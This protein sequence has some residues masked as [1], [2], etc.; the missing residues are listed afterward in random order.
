MTLSLGMEADYASLI[1][2]QQLDSLKMIGEADKYA[3]KLLVTAP[4]AADAYLTLGTADYVIGSLPDSRGFSSASLES[5]A[6]RKRGSSSSRSPPITATTCDRLRRF[7]WR[8]WPC[9]K[10]SQKSPALS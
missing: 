4:G 9:A 2:K 6:T 3:K 5:T 8:W 1:D 10:R 7:C